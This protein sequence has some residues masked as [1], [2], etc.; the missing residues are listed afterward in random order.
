MVAT[1]W[2]DQQL[3]VFDIESQSLSVF[4]GTPAGSAP[5]KSG[6]GGGGGGVAQLHEPL[7][8]PGSIVGLV[9]DGANPGSVL[10]WGHGFLAEV[11]LR[12][13]AT[14]ADAAADGGGGGGGDGDGAM[15]QEDGGGGGGS[16]HRTRA[17]VNN[18][19]GPLLY[20]GVLGPSTVVTVERPWASVLGGL[21]DA[22]VQ[23]KYGT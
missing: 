1:S 10:A 4:G 7:G 13:A 22:I 17:K 3:Y 15:E 9:A 21:S 23:P 20:A 6:G 14:T 5:A 18:K 8:L 12:P 11:P 2:P 16:R 19:V